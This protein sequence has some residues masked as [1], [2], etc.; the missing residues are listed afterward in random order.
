MNIFIL[1]RKEDGSID[2]KKS[3]EV[4]DNYRIVKMP[5][6]NAQMACTNLNFLAN[7]QIASYRSV[8][9]NHPCTIWARRR[10]NNFLQ[11]IQHG[12]FM[13]EEYTNRFG[14]KHKCEDVLYKC[15][16]L[17]EHPK[18]LWEEEDLTF[19]MPLCMPDEYKSDDI[20]ESYRRFYSQ[21]PRMRYIK[22]TEPEWFIKYRGNKPYE[23]IE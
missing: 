6:E 5:L 8:H 21:K 23:V 17:M 9:K 12:I 16:E 22:G 1:E 20:V 4:L 7:Y 13:C 18:V 3:A 2:W 10:Y 19:K 14:K 11:L 15:Y